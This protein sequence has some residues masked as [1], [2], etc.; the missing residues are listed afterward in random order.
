M[1]KGVG[2]AFF[3]EGVGGRFEGVTGFFEGV[4][5]LFEGVT[6]LFEG[7]TG[8]FEGVGAACVLV[9]DG[10]NFFALAVLV[11]D[12]ENR[13]VIFFDGDGETAS[14]TW[15]TQINSVKV[16]RMQRIWL[17]LLSSKMKTSL[18]LSSMKDQGAKSLNREFRTLF[19]ASDF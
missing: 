18:A 10:V 7:V 11:R 19:S 5:G 15:I 16:N 17:I 2:V 13:S 14:T 4:T 8:L 1:T 12:G 3:R 6:G 9:R